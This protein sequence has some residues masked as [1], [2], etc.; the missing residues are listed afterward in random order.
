MEDLAMTDLSVFRNK[1]VLLTG[2]TGFK[3]AWMAAWLDMLGA[4]VTGI[5]LDPLDDKGVFPITGISNHIKD[6]RADIRDLGRMHQIF[7]SE[8]PEIVFHMAAQPLVLESYR[9]PVDTFAIN[10]L[11][12]ANILEA[13]RNTP[14]V[15]AA[16][17]ITTDKCY[18]NR[19]WVH[20]Y[21]ESDPMGGHDP[22]SASKGAA[23]IVISSYRRSF[24]SGAHPAAIASARSGNVIGGG[25]WSANRLVP[26]IMRAVE[27]GKTLEIRSPESVRPWQHV[28]EPLSGYLLLAARLLENPAGFSEAWNFGPLPHQLFSVR[29][30]A[31]AF[32]R[33]LGKGEWKDVS[34]PSQLHEA[35]LLML[36]ISKAVHR[37]GWKP[38]L[39]FEQMIRFTAEWYASAPRQ[40]ALELCRHQIRKY[41]QL[42][43][44]GSEN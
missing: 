2:H 33:H 38:V 30:V 8:A 15:K 44:S 3:G 1:K 24:F 18:E 10:T 13:I 23:E 42:W 7:N 41:T 32:L 21:R 9:A 25:D 5:A 22:Y 37:L 31:D 14:S 6:Y 27:S 20:G 11:G 39:N 12:T 16:V 28:L 29:Q 43:T 19:E 26:D 35:G 34:D 17:M 4:R 40:D 36:D